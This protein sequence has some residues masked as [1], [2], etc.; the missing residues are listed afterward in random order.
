[1]SKTLSCV[2]AGLLGLSLSAPAETFHEIG[3]FLGSVSSVTDYSFAGLGLR[4]EFG[5]LRDSGQYSAEFRFAG[6]MYEVDDRSQA[7]P[8]G[9]YDITALELGFKYAKPLTQVS[10]YVVIGLG[11]YTFEDPS[12]YEYDA[13]TGF[14]LAGGVE[15]LA[16]RT[17]SVQLFAQLRYTQATDDVEGN[18]YGTEYGLDGLGF[19]AGVGF[20]F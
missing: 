9:D 14:H 13:L 11:H 7:G 5:T 17:K 1:M 3:T 4:Y 15:L 18:S 16:G 8:I 6:F 10:P 12:S 19:D 20:R 2:A